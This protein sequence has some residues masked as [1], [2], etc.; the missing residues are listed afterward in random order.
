MTILFRNR[1]P[2]LFASLL[3][4]ALILA[5]SF[6]ALSLIFAI[7]L[8]L[9]SFGLASFVAI[10]KHRQAYRQGS[11]RRKEFLRNASFEVLGILLAMI[12]ASLVGKE[13]AHMAAGQ[14]DDALFRALAGILIGFLTGLGTGILIRR[15][16]GRLVRL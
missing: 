10:H 14:I 2:L 15:L 6:P 3:V 4:G 11:I 5:W 16:W 7:T 8:L 1:L 9:L 13:I 12:L